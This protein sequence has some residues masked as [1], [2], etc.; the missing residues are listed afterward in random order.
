MRIGIVNDVSMAVEVLRR[1]VAGGGHEVAWT[2]RDGAEAVEQCAA[3]T[4]DLVLMDLIMPV[5]DGVRATAAIMQRCPCAILVVTAT[6]SG[7]AAK[8]FDAM[9][10]GALDAAYTPVVGTDGALT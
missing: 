3:D 10:C 9:G 4:P 6:V 1:V 5:M 2:A 8:V 7:H